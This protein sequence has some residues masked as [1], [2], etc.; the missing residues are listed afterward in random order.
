RKASARCAR[1]SSDARPR[2]RRAIRCRGIPASPVRVATSFSLACSL[3]ENAFEAVGLRLDDSHVADL[4]DQR[5]RAL[6]MHGLKIRRAPDRLIALAPRLLEQ[7]RQGTALAGLA[8][9]L[10]LR[11]Q[12]RLQRFETRRLDV[13]GNLL[14]RGGSRRARTAAVFEREGLRIADV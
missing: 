14:A 3:G 8:E 12:K 7:H 4:P 1:S 11:G 13:F 2:A 5:A 6:D 9:F 10:L